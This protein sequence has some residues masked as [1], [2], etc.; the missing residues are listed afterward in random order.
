MSHGTHRT[1]LKQN[2]NPK[3]T[4]RTANFFPKN[5]TRKHFSI[6]NLRLMLNVRFFSEGPQTLSLNNI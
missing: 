3:K 4:P 6:T 2:K 5:L 1:I